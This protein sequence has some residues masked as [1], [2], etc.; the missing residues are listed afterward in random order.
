[1]CTL[2]VQNVGSAEKLNTQKF[3][4]LK[5]NCVHYMYGW[6]GFAKKLNI[7]NSIN[8]T[9]NCVHKCTN[10]LDLQKNLISWIV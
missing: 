4:N 8:S 7:R 1:M 2:Y 3:V 6:S 9:R 5:G 10:G